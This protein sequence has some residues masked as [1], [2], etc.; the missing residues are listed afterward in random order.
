MKLRP[1]E[2]KEMAPMLVAE[3]GDDLTNQLSGTGER[4]SVSGSKREV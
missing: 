1:R 4:E 3:L 2:V